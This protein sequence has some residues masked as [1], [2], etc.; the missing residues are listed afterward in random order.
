[1]DWPEDRRV[2]DIGDQFMFGPAFLV[3]PI[4]EPAAESRSVY[5][6][7]APA[8]YDFWTGKRLP[9]AE[10]IE[11]AAPLERIPLFVR[12]GSIVPLGPVVQ[13]AE[14]AADLLEV[15]VYPGADGH[16]E[17]YSDAGDSYDYEKGQHRI[18]P[19]RWEDAART[20][21]LGEGQGSYPGMPAHVRIRLI[22][23][24]QTHGVGEKRTS[25]S[26]GEAWYEG[27]PL[28]IAARRDVDLE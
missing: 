17:W 6:P 26:D 10:S 22:V 2:R 11:A 7:A 19:L 14:A 9:G 23:V 15:R 13:D 16:F 18:V 28:R 12:A 1:M 24:R 5:L 27:R 3:A 21:V 25:V 4:T 8:W 20:L